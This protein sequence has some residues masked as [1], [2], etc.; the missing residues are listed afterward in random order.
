MEN[1]KIKDLQRDR[2]RGF[3]C[4]SGPIFVQIL[5]F[6][7]FL[8]FPKVSSLLFTSCLG[9]FGC[10]GFCNGLL[11]F[12][13]FVR[14]CKKSRRAS[15]KRVRGEM[16]EREREKEIERERVSETATLAL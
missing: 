15:R 5:D 11:I 6:W 8:D 9:F 2:A 1:Q 12:L 16:K 10:V 14:P 3:F 13:S 7:D 4:I